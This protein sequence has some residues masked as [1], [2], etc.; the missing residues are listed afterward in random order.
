MTTTATTRESAAAFSYAQAA[1]GRA[2]A[3]AQLLSSQNTSGANTPSKDMSLS[4][5]PTLD[6]S[7]TT[8][9]SDAERSTNGDADPKVAGTLASSTTASFQNSVP[10]SPSYGTAST[11]TL[12]REEEAVATAPKLSSDSPWDRPAA[13]ENVSEKP[14]GDRRKS[15]KGKKDKNAD[16]DAEKEK[17]EPKPVEILVAAPPPAVNFWQQRM[18]SKPAS[19]E[20]TAAEASTAE[21]KPSSEKRKPKAAGAEEGEK[22]A[23]ANGAPREGKGQKK[24]ADSNRGKEDYNKRSAPRGSRVGDKDEKSAANQLPPP[25]GDA[26][27]WPTPETALEEEKRKAQEKVDK[28]EKDTESSASKQPRQKEKWV[29]VPYTPSVTFNTPL[30]V[31]GARGRAGRPAGRDGGG[32]GAQSSNDGPGDKTEA[33]GGSDNRERGRDNAGSGR[34]TSLPPNASKRSAGDSYRD[35]RKPTTAEK[36]SEAAAKADAA[37]ANGR[38]SSVATQTENSANGPTDGARKNEQTNGV[39]DSHA[40][41]HSAGY[42]M[43]SEFNARAGDFQKD[44]NGHQ[45]RERGEGRSERGRGGYRGGRGNHNNFPNGQQHPQQ[46]YSNGQVQ[47]PINGYGM[48][49]NGPYSPTPPSQ[50]FPGGFPQPAQRGR[51]GAPPPRSQS[52]PNSG[53]MYPRYPAGPNGPPMMSPIS[54]NGAM[55][56]Y[57]GMQSMSAAPYN[58]YVEPYSVMAMVTMQLEY[59]FSIDNLCKDVFLRK[60]MDSQGFVFLTFIA[61]FKRIQSLTQDFELLRYACQES[62]VIEIVV[63]EDGIDR[64]RRNDGWEKWVLPTDDRD[65]AARNNGPERFYRQ[66]HPQRGQQMPP[67]M[68]P[69]GPGGPPPPFSPNGVQSFT[70]YAAG[71]PNLNGEN[72]FVP[73]PTHDSPLSAAVPEFAPAPAYN[74]SDYVDVPTTFSDEEIMHLTVVYSQKAPGEASQRIPYNASSRT[75]SN[76]SI[77]ARLINEE[78]QELEKRQGRPLTNGN[79]ESSEISPERLRNSLSPTTSTMSPTRLVFGNAPPV[80]WLKSQ[81]EQPTTSTTSAPEPKTNEPYNEI[82]SRALQNRTPTGDIN[83]DM[84]VLYQFWA[85]F[86]I[87]NFNPAMYEEFRRCAFEDSARGAMFGVNLLVTYYDEVL[88]SKKRTIPEVF[89][90]HF[91]ELVRGEDKSAG[92]PAFTR[93]RAAWRNGAL[94]MKS[95]KKVD[96]FVDAGLREELER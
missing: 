32:R 27:S 96:G 61:G 71:S 7:N 11:S 56:E 66:S 21:A 64:L 76:G 3:N 62:D 82:R 91:V 79:S 94:D 86:L 8:A 67:R 95:R 81:S 35:A 68:M 6:F 25:V 90:R 42:D 29:S 33:N 47:Q 85:H 45:G 60:H 63:G 22:P 72:G 50:Q 53:P 1:K 20:P 70:P 83:N 58:P 48:R 40:H 74:A 73:P 10:T 54:T 92:R 80:M 77:D 88:N 52:N 17:E 55:F 5:E 49:P 36:K 34:A 19:E 51:S 78:L 26:I 65:E 59:Y 31:R 84:K 28:D 89:A 44:A 16:K 14:E 12:P 46:G 69:Q 75:F 18:A 39:A 24:N 15:R 13:S 9:T 87:R 30:P 4:V 93:L 57:P 2:A 37:A 43:R 23:G 41:P 38:R